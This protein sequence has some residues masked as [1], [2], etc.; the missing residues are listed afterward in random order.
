[1]TKVLIGNFAPHSG[2]E[3][4]QAKA[5]ELINSIEADGSQVFSLNMT[6]EGSI[7]VLARLPKSAPSAAAETP[8]AAPAPET[9]TDK[10]RDDAGAGSSTA[11]TTGSA[12]A[13]DSGSSKG[14]NQNSG[15]KK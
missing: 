3:G 13:A 2:S 12:P 11:P 10:T 7:I 4:A 5:Q 8:P 9:N 6:V 14:P 1:M 15:P